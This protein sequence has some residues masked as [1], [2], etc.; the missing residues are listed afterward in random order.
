MS[1]QLFFPSFLSSFLSQFSLTGFNLWSSSGSQILEVSI[2][3]ISEIVFIYDDHLCVVAG[4]GWLESGASE[5]FTTD[6]IILIHAPFLII[7]IIL[8]SFFGFKKI[9]F[10]DFFDAHTCLIHY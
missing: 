9:L 2:L 10:L 8:K 4:G 1:I 5:I 3:L 7:I 6:F